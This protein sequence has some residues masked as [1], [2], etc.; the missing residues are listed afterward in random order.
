MPRT[1]PEWIGKTDDAPVPPRV[2]PF[3]SP[4]RRL[5]SPDLPR[6]RLDLRPHRKAL[7]HA[8][9]KLR[10]RGR[11]LPGTVASGWRRRMDGRWERRP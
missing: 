10:P 6:R 3:R 5:P 4:L 2:H 7:R 1:L 11:P 9:I 8:G